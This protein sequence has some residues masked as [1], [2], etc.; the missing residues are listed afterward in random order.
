M[1]ANPQN[2]TEATLRSP[3]EHYEANHPIA[4]WGNFGE[5]T[6]NRTVRNLGL[7]LSSMA[8]K[9]GLGCHCR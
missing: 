9:D 2:A 3:Q 7:P 4:D 1:S 6:G 8:N 5:F